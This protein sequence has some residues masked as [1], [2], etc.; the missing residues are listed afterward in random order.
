MFGK[1]LISK[2]DL[3]EIQNKA[4]AFDIITDVFEEK[5]GGGIKNKWQTAVY[6]GRQLK[7]KKI[8]K[9]EYKKLINELRA[10]DRRTD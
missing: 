1:I 5:F 7:L 3:I 4:D 8:T 10:N 6:Y 9:D 2:A